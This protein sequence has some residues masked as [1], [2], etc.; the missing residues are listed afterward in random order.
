M[1]VCVW[2]GGGP[3]DDR[4]DQVVFFDR[5]VNSR[6]GF[7]PSAPNSC[8]LTPTTAGINFLAAAPARG[9]L[10]VL[11]LAMPAALALAL[12]VATLL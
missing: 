1:C 4:S 10:A 11:A 5:G 8:S 6:I 12:A 2:G 9:P 3:P 7:A